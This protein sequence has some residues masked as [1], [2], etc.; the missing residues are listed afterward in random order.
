MLAIKHGYKIARIPY[1][2]TDEYEIL[3]ELG[4]IF[5]SKPTY[6]PIPVIDQALYK[7]NQEAVILTPPPRFPSQP[8]DPRTFLSTYQAFQSH[9]A[10]LT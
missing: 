5:E 7:P 6:P 1:W 2:V 8:Y 10:P 9:K 4:N 3:I